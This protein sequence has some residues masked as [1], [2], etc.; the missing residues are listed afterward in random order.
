MVEFL[1]M[2]GYA[3]YV[4]PAFAIPTV[5]ML[6]VWWQSRR[7]LSLSERTIGELEQDLAQ[8]R[9]A[10]GAPGTGEPAAP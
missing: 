2:G 9:S 4:W 3:G 8:K 5:L 10:G 7:Q 6:A 1:A